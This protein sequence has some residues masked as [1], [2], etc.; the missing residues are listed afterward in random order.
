[1]VN[2]RGI[3]ITEMGGLI[4]IAEA[5]VPRFTHPLLTATFLIEVLHS[6][7]ETVYRFSHL[8]AQDFLN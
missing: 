4:S 3:K 5:Y 1:M 2:Y 6:A 7:A 8:L